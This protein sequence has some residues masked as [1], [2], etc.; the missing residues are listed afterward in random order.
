MSSPLAIPGNQRAACSSLQYSM[1]YGVVDVVV[2]AT[3]SRVGAPRCRR[4]LH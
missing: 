2:Q 1:K 3:P 4:A